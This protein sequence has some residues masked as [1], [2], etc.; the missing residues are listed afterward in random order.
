MARFNLPKDTA[1]C[2]FEIPK[3]AQQTQFAQH[4]YQDNKG[5]WTIKKF[6]GGQEHTLICKIT[7]KQSTS[8]MARKEIGPVSLNFEI[9]MFNVS[10]L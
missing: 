6:Q 2:T 9:P 3:Q 1:A 10:K 8:N 5:E 7:L 4:N